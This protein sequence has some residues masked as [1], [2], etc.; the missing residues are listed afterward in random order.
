MPA[1]FNDSSRDA[2]TESLLAELINDVG[3]FFLIDLG[4]KV[5][6]RDS[7]FGTK[8]QVEGSAGSERKAWPVPPTRVFFIRSDG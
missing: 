3:K 8:P 4:K 7:F 1:T 2:T 6:C 5:T